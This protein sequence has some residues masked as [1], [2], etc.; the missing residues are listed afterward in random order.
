[1]GNFDRFVSHKQK[2][3]G[4]I[5]NF[6]DYKS[7]LGPKSLT[8]ILSDIKLYYNARLIKTMCYWYKNI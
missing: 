5:N 7:V 4:F 3:F 6:Y 2:L 1:M 8:T